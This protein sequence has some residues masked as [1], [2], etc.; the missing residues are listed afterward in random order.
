MSFLVAR[1]WSWLV[2]MTFNQQ[3][4]KAIFR[5]CLL[6]CCGVYMSSI[7]SSV[8][9]WR[10]M[11][12]AGSCFVNIRNLM[13]CDTLYCDV[14][15]SFLSLQVLL[16]FDWP[17]PSYPLH[18]SRP[19][20][21]FEI[22]TYLPG[23]SPE[24]RQDCHGFLQNAS[25]NT[26]VWRFPK[27]APLQRRLD[28]REHVHVLGQWECR[29]WHVRFNAVEGALGSSLLK[30]NTPAQPPTTR[31]AT[32]ATTRTR[33]RRSQIKK[34]TR[35]TTQMREMGVKWPGWLTLLEQDWIALQRRFREQLEE[36][37]PSRLLVFEV[38]SGWFGP[39]GHALKSHKIWISKSIKLHTRYTYLLCWLILFTCAM[40]CQV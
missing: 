38:R 17:Y 20:P 5:L 16:E 34:R 30:L 6:N 11:E 19:L 15:L 3:L 37:L 36:T 25:L 14:Q 1:P 26:A 35:T 9:W 21:W 22:V 12:C 24:K 8:V 13:W 18:I 27:R 28:A 4:L 39:Q 29:L 33:T 23:F 7:C 32:T 10:S 40:L 2:D 31:T